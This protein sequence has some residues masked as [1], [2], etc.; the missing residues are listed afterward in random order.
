MLNRSNLAAEVAKLI[1]QLPPFPQVVVQILD[2]L[3]DE[4]A[5]LDAITRLTRNDPVITS[6]V[7]ATANHIRRLHAQPDVYDPFLAA[8]LIGLNQFRRIVVSA[9]LNKF[10]GQ[11][12]GAA[13]LLQH[14]RAVAIVAQELAMLCGVSPEKAYIAGILH[15]VGQLYFHV[16]DP[17]RFQAVQAQSALDGRLLD[18]EAEAFGLDHAVVGGELAR[19]WELPEAFAL[20]IEAHHEMLVATSPL[21]AL[22]NVAESLTRALDLPPSPK[23]HLSR[24][25]LVAVA[26]LGIDWHSQEMHDCFGRC[27]ARF[28]L[29][30]F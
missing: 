18:H 10:I 20:A 4:D 2:M 28:G 30:K 14:S 1:K 22:V 16:R 9:A 27:R 21:Q 6:S 29:L 8:S 12:K 7:L 11:D 5:S 13:F 25:N 24:I 3:H 26:H 23:N 19:Q 17:E 15:D